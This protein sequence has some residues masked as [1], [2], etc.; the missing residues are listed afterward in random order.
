VS[1]T[2]QCVVLLRSIALEMGSK[3]HSLW[4]GH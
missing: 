2:L 1:V 4:H 3:R